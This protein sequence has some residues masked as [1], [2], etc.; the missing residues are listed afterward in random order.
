MSIDAAV[1]GE[2]TQ[3][4]RFADNIDSTVL[5]AYPLARAIEAVTPFSQ[6]AGLETVATERFNLLK[7]QRRR[8]LVTVEGADYVT[9]SDFA[10]QCPAAVLKSSR[11][12][13]SAGRTMVIVKFEVDYGTNVTRLLLWG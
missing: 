10:G 2:L 12:G 7:V 9:A 13:L 5:S 6:V 8:F 4:F 1:Y 11:F 3:P